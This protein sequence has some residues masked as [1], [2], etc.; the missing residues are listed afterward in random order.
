MTPADK[1]SLETM[2]F[3]VGSEVVTHKPVANVDSDVEDEPEGENDSLYER[4]P[5]QQ[6]VKRGKANTSEGPYE[7]PAILRTKPWA[8]SVVEAGDTEA[9]DSEIERVVITP[10]K[11]KK[12]MRVSSGDNSE[13]VDD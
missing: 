12:A 11:G 10:A 6:D 3:Q 7:T 13:S 8:P 9:E 4:T 1:I 2:I 5:R